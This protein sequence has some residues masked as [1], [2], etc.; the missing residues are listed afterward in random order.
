MCMVGSII[1]DDPKEFLLHRVCCLPGVTCRQC[2]CSSNSPAMFLEES[3]ESFSH[4]LSLVL[5]SSAPPPHLG[6]LSV[7]GF[8]P[9]CRFGFFDGF[10]SQPDRAAM[11]CKSVT[12]SPSGCVS[13]WEASRSK[14]C[15]T[16]ESSRS[17]GVSVQQMSL[18]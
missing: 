12:P 15:K 18:R 11:S 1:K 4:L 6:K 13:H 8:T 17:P 14:T 7:F 5:K 2:C 3:V 16:F 10:H 9:C